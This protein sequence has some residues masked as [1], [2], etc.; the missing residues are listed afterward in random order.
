MT[1]TEPVDF[2]ALPWSFVES[3][4]GESCKLF[5]FVAGFGFTRS[6]APTGLVNKPNAA[7]PR[8]TPHVPHRRVFRIE[9]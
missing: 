5:A 3:T 8:I 4:V 6:S 1:S 7:K 9:P 2:S